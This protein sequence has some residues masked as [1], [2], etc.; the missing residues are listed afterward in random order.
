M[1]NAFWRVVYWIEELAERIKGKHCV[2]CGRRLPYGAP[3]YYYITCPPGMSC[4]DCYNRH[5]QRLFRGRD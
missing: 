1:R 4:E 2:K 5:C 3:S